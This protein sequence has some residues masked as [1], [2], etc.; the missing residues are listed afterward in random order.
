MGAASK[1]V[2]VTLRVLELI[3]AS[4]VAGILGRLLHLVHVAHGHF[5]DRLVYAV[6]IAGLS[7]FY[8]LCL[9]L[10]FLYSFLA[11]PLDIIM[12][13]LWM[14]AFGLL[15]GVGHP[16]RTESSTNAGQLV[17]GRSCSS[18]WYTNYWGLYWG[19]LWAA[20]RRSWFRLSGCSSWR[21]ALAFTFIGSI[22]WLLSGCLARIGS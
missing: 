3:S 7:I 1:A 22:L 9:I 16:C 17:V 14:V 4:I 10:P 5:N 20:P 8:S 2:S 18:G 13:I 21:T 19:R 15:E 11:F 6:T 12:F